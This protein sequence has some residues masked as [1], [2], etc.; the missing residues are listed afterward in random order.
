MARNTNLARVKDFCFEWDLEVEY[1]VF[2][3]VYGPSEPGSGGLNLSGP[4][5]L[6]EQIE[7]YDVYVTN[8]K[9]QKVSLTP[10]LDESTI[11]ALE[12]EIYEQL[13]D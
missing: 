13:H 9:G 8:E 11:I 4:A 10:L 6:P 1:E 12:D 2:P 3:A 5:N 7:I